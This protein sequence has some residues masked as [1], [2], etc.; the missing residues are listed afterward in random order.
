MARKY[1][2]KDDKV[3]DQ[4]N[5]KLDKILEI[6]NGNGKIGL[7]AQVEI[8]KDDIGDL[9]KRPSNI[10]SWLVAGAVILQMV[11]TGFAIYKGAL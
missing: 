11:I 5:E 2:R 9:K 10:K 3:I 6:L 4:V 7:C 1:T 8:N